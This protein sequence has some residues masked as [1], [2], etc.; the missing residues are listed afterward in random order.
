MAWKSWRQEASYIYL[1]TVCWLGAGEAGPAHLA[2]VGLQGEGEADR[3]VP[4]P[5]HLQ[6]TAG[7]AE[8]I[9]LKICYSGQY[10]KSALWG[11]LSAEGATAEMWNCWKL[12]IKY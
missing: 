3:P 6:T 5:H 1:E 2:R 4:G 8:N 10:A 9:S 11:K 12:S 7:Q